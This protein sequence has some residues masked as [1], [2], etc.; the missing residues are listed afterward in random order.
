M[1]VS[2]NSKPIHPQTSRDSVPKL[3][4]I[5]LRAQDPW[6]QEQLAGAGAAQSTQGCV[7][8]GCPHAGGTGGMFGATLGTDTARRALPAGFASPRY[9]SVLM[10]K[11]PGV[12]EV[13][14]LPREEGEHWEHPEVSPSLLS[15]RTSHGALPTGKKEQD[16][17]AV[18]KGSR[19]R[20]KEPPG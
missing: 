5:S 7:W 19:D 1:L 16:D 8:Q 14:Q 15:C 17:P 2:I 3:V 18:P 10:S 20:W 6:L 9:H 11:F 13:E 12:N 4:L